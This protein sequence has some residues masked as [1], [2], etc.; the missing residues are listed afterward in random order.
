[1]IISAVVAMNSSF[2]IGKDNDLPW[3]LKEDLEHFKAYTLGKPIIMGRKT[4]ESI[5][6]PLPNRLNVVVSRTISEIDNLL[7]VSTLKKAINEARI[8]C[9]SNG[10]DE[11]VLIGGAGI[12]KEGLEILN[13]LVITWVNADDL[14]GDVYFP[15]FSLDEWKETDSKDFSRSADNQFDFTIKEYVKL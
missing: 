13:K 7:T 3:K 5:G 14:E 15:S 2:L 11:I 9:E 10:Q 12:F 4:Y 6:R 1:M 8:Y